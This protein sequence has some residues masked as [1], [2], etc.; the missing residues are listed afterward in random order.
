MRFET[1]AS[2]E[3]STRSPSTV[4]PGGTHSVEP[5]A[6]ST[7]VASIAPSSSPVTATR[8]G[9]ASRPR[10]RTSVIVF[11]LKQRLH[12]LAEAVGALAA[13]VDHLAV[14]ETQ[15]AGD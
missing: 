5:V 2:R 12:A 8:V 4:T 14:V 15:L 7:C 10:P 3:V 11:F 9:D 6:S 1:S 13:V